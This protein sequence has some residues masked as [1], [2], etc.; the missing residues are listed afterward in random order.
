MQ[1][2]RRLYGVF[3]TW[4]LLQDT[5]KRETLGEEGIDLARVFHKGLEETYGQKPIWCTLES[6][7]N[8]RTPPRW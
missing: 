1:S 7:R 8:H 2:R 5:S 3:A 4:N 6:V